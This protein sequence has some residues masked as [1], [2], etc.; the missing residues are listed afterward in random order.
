MSEITVYGF[1]VGCKYCD[2]AKNTL[3]DRG[4]DFKFVDVRE[5]ANT[6]ALFKQVHNT[7][8]QIY[9]DGKCMGGSEA[10]EFVGGEDYGDL[11][12]D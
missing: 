5:D 8:P 6:L 2:I 11:S 4:V 1:T 9:E 10:A 7:V 12:L 3:V